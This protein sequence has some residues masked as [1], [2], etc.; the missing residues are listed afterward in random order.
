MSRITDVDIRL[1]RVFTTIVECNGFSGAQVELN[2]GV[3]TISTHMS[4]LEAQLGVRLC[5][6][7]RGGFGLTDKGRVIYEAAKQLF[8]ALDDFR[9]TAGAQRG[10]LTGNL[11]LGVVDS[12]V[13]NP[14]VRLQD[15]IRRFNERQH[16]VH[17]NL[18][19]DARQELERAVLDGRLHA[20]IGPSERHTPVLE[21]TR[22]CTEEHAVYC[23][24]GHPLYDRPDADITMADIADSSF[25]ARGYMDRADLERLDIRKHGATVFNMEAQAILILSGGYIGF[26][27]A[28]FAE[29]WVETAELRQIRR[30][31]LGYLSQFYLITR[32]G[33]RQTLVNRTFLADL[34]AELA[35]EG[36]ATPAGAA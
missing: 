7:G 11:N 19:I 9:A 20:A 18:V 17:M 8:A 34:R 26:L 31:E 6:R 27:P 30:H 15:V 35:L 22:L 16:D 21:Y 2:V 24:R 4:S 32:R 28:H 33:A 5:R 3:S 10:Q 13:T 29:Q 25:V 23:G 36:E 14:D 12:I 1:L